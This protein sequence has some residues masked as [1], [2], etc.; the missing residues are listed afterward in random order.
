M[1]PVLQVGNRTITAEEITPLLTS[2]QML[3]RLLV[4]IIIDQAIAPI[5]CTAEEMA[6]NYRQFYQQNQL[7]TETE[8]QAWL[9]RYKMTPEQL[10]ALA[11]RGL[12]I[13]KFKQANWGHKLE[14]YFLSCKSQLDKVIYSLIRTTEADVASEL[15]FRIQEGEQPFADLARQY[16]SGQE[17]NTGGLIGPVDLSIPHPTL[18]KMLSVSQPGQLWPP[19]R[20]GEWQVIVRLEKF[21]PATLDE[22]MRTRLLNELFADWLSEQLNQLSDL[23]PQRVSATIA[24]Q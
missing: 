14:S 19:I 17:A 23:R 3:P 24:N 21:I 1:T 20:L 11:T 16:S 8:L 4:E 18:A 6:D 15:Y 10:A 7:T 12:K 5:T 13:E 22:A 9:E 2:Y